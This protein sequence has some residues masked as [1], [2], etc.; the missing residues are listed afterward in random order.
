[1]LVFKWDEHSVKSWLRLN[2]LFLSVL[3]AMKKSIKR[4]LLKALIVFAAGCAGGLVNSIVV[5]LFG[6]LG[7]TT[8]LGVNIVPNLTAAWLYPRIVWGGI[9]GV[10][11]SLAFCWWFLFCSR[12]A[13]QYRT[14]FGA[15]IDCFSPQSSKGVTGIAV[16]NNY[17]FVCINFQCC[18]GSY[19]SLSN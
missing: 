4:L 16:R 12:S 17:S 2:L 5:W 7:I 6:H 18:L 14:V 11:F 19:S 15:A 13:L 10:S 9:W 3:L 1:M 8:A